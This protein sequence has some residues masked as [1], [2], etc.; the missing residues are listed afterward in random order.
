MKVLCPICH[1]EGF[2][3]NPCPTTTQCLVCKTCGGSGL[4]EIFWGCNEQMIKNGEE[5][6]K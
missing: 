3:V 4:V 2:I 6:Y 5:L 1:G